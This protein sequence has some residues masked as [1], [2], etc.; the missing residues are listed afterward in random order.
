VLCFTHELKDK[1]SI[2]YEGEGKFI[3][4]AFYIPVL[5]LSKKYDRISGYVDSLVITKEGRRKSNKEA[6]C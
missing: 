4:D 2:Y 6:V 1:L 5:K 3:A